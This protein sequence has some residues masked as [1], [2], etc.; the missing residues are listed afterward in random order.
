MCITGYCLK[1]S[2]KDY[3]EKIHNFG[4]CI[5]INIRS[6]PDKLDNLKKILAHLDNE[7]IHF[8]AV[9]LF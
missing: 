1:Y 3:R 9:K 8:D 2:F 4:A 7:Q 6:L 5:Y